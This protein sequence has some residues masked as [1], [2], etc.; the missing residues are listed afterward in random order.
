MTWRRTDTSV[1]DL[2]PAFGRREGMAHLEETGADL[3]SAG[4][5][6]ALG[7]CRVAL[8]CLL[9]TIGLSTGVE[10]RNRGA[11]VEETGQGFGSEGAA[12]D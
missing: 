5:A 8:G 10:E 2:D 7:E 11:H 3:D 1:V 12:R 9:L 6:I 4:P